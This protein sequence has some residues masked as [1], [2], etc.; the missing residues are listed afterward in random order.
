MSSDPDSNTTPDFSEHFFCKDRPALPHPFKVPTHDEWRLH[1]DGTHTCSW[2]GS[3]HPWDFVEIMEKYADGVEGYSFSTTSKTY[4]AY[5]HGPGVSNASEGGIKFYG[6]HLPAEGGDLGQRFRQAESR[7][8]AEF[9]RR[10][11]ARYDHA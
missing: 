6:W 9:A 8:R 4:K 11:K 10:M 5:G 7:A 3:L 2:C 1:G